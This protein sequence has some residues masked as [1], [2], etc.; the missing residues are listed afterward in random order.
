VHAHRKQK[1]RKD[2]PRATLKL[3]LLDTCTCLLGILYSLGPPYYLQAWMW[4]WMWMWMESYSDF[5]FP[6]LE[7]S[8][9]ASP[10]NQKTLFFWLTLRTIFSLSLTHLPW[11]TMSACHVIIQSDLWPIFSFLFSI[12][13]G[14]NHPLSTF[15]YPVPY[16]CIYHLMSFS[17][18]RGW[19]MNR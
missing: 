3:Q 18:P 12:F 7:A 11:S 17:P 15:V 16:V 10:T 2:T 1:G 13:L 5:H 14:D 4:M 9:Y 6:Q 8:L 19:I